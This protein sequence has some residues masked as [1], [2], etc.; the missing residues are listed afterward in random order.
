M[1]A[2]DLTSYDLC[3]ATEKLEVER[4]AGRYKGHFPVDAQWLAE[5]YNVLKKEVERGV[6]TYW[7]AK[8]LHTGFG[9]KHSLY[10]EGGDD[11]LRYGVDLSYNKVAGVM[12]GSDR[13]TVSGAITLSYRYKSLLFRNVLSTTFNRRMIR[14]MGAFRNIRN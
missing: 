9:H 8:P 3:D 2:P 1:T 13:E 7:L 14:L 4:T 12:K 10:L 5:E 6:N 11:Y